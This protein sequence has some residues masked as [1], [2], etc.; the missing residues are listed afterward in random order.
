[1][2]IHTGTEH[3]GPDIAIS[4]VLSYCATSFVMRV[5]DPR[6]FSACPFILLFLHLS[7]I[8]HLPTVQ[9]FGD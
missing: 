9:Q 7:N 4:G 1:M 2:A 3:S 8:Y 5:T 6:A